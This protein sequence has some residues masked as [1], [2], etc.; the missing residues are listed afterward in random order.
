M[1]CPGPLT[2]FGGGSFSLMLLAVSFSGFFAL[3]SFVGWKNDL[4]EHKGV[5]DIISTEAPPTWATP[6][7]PDTIPSHA[8]CSTFV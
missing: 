2:Y 6:A 4:E 7:A 5:R 8:D 1:P 3:P